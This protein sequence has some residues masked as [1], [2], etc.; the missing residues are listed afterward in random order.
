MQIQLHTDFSDV[1]FSVSFTYKVC[2]VFRNAI[3]TCYYFYGSGFLE[4]F[5]ESIT[6]AILSAFSDHPST[7]AEVTLVVQ[8]CGYQM[9]C[10][11]GESKKDDLAIKGHLLVQDT[12]VESLNYHLTKSWK[13]I[14][15][16][17]IFPWVL[18]GGYAKNKHGK[19]T[20]CKEHHLRQYSFSCTKWHLIWE[21]VK[22]G[23]PRQA[24]W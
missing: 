22:D 23:N 20:V 16:W 14:C 7:L 1:D 8:I 4:C 13:A 2:K 6:I 11:F 9:L 19:E 21:E 18:G 10:Y 5:L 17:Q 15:S 24:G 12:L 3:A